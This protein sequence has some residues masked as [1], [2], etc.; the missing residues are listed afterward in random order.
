MPAGTGAEAYCA[1]NEERIYVVEGYS[2]PPSVTHNSVEA[3]PE[4]DGVFFTAIL[5]VACKVQ[6][7]SERARGYHV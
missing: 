7:R 6:R 5:R 4:A 1:S 3:T 2:A